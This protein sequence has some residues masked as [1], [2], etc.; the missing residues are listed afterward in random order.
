MFAAGESYRV[1]NNLGIN[2][3]HHYI[4]HYND[5]ESGLGYNGNIAALKKIQTYEVQC[6]AN[7][8]T[9]M[10]SVQEGNGTL[11]DNSVVLFASEF[12]DST[13]HDLKHMPVLLA[14]GAGGRFKA[15]GQHLKM[16]DGTRYAQV[17]LTAMRGCGL[18]QAS[19][20]ALG[21]TGSL[22]GV[23]G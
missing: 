17:L 18:T 1:Y 23:L 22:A 15:Q 14:G 3:K 2:A 16:A 10:R 9:A 5:G 11:L 19:F 6:F 12:G 20:G 4:S 21:E 8:L 7:L 13:S